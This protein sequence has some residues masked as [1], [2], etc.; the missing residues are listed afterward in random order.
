MGNPAGCS[1]LEI[2]VLGEDPNTEWQ[3][4]IL[5]YDPTSDSW[6]MGNPAPVGHATAAG[7]TTGMKAPKRIYSFDENQ[8]DLYDPVSSTW[9]T[10][11][12]VPTDRLIAKAVVFDDLFFLIGGRT[13]MRVH[14]VY[15]P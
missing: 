10:G 11:T 12:S 2:Y 15:V 5:T 13:G 4:V 7:A 1:A 3:N 14:D 6:S 9:T 8:T